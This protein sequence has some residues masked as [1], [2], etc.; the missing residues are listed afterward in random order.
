M[1]K[2]KQF[3]ETGKFLSLQVDIWFD[4]FYS[5]TPPEPSLTSISLSGD[6]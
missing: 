3:I 4:H 6:F 2:V 1:K 5:S